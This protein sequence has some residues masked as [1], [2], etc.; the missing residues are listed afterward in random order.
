MR[1]WMIA[2]MLLALA[3]LAACDFSV[4]G[5]EAKVP[6]AAPAPIINDPQVSFMWNGACPYRTIEDL[7]TPDSLGNTKD[8][9][10]HNPI[11]AFTGG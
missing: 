8:T 2:G 1:D 7:A 3:G 11:G 10:L 9:I 4:F 6:C 5:V